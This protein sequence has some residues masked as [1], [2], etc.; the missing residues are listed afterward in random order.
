MPLAIFWNLCKP[1][2]RCKLLGIYLSSYFLMTCDNRIACDT[3]PLQKNQMVYS[4]STI[5]IVHQRPVAPTWTTC[6]TWELSCCLQPSSL[7]ASHSS[8]GRLVS[9]LPL[10]TLFWYIH[11]SRCWIPAE[12][13][14][15]FQRDTTLI[16]SLT[17]MIN[18]LQH[19]GHSQ[20]I[21]AQETQPRIWPLCPSHWPPVSEARRSYELPKWILH[22]ASDS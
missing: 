6:F 3:R 20:N 13:E 1:R 17:L 7:V 10:F 21:F 22:N 8:A 4:P 15:Q 9:F 18:H 16:S 5:N 2:Y 12:P 11:K 14:F 19:G